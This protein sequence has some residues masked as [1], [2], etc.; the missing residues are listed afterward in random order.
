MKCVIQ[1]ENARL[2]RNGQAIL[3]N[4][5]ISIM[6]GQTV[7]VTGHNGSGKSTLVKLL[8]G[9]HE[10]SDGKVIRNF[11]FYG[12]VPEHF[13][14]GIRLTVARYLEFLVQMSNT[15]QEKVSQYIEQFN[16]TP[17]LHTSLKN[18]SKGTKQKVGFIQAIMKEADV[19]FFD[20]PFTGMDEAAQQH[21]I[22]LLLSLRGEK[23]MVF[24]LHEEALVQQLATHR[25]TLP[26]GKMEKL[27]K[28]EN[29]K[30]RS[31]TVRSE[32]PVEGALQLEEN[33]YRLFVPEDDSD[34]R[35]M[36]LLTAGCRVLEVGE[37]R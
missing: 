17:Y 35:L 5:N 36:Q 6:E 12:Y 10:P 37:K 19:L 3:S 18:C 30:M 31:I 24:V 7:A 28:K 23:T 2:D 21:A 4:L 20:E 34:E 1:T 14:E 25:I 15:D 16:L 32:Q 33:I 9:I 11:Q 22:N 27:T 26:S 13:P 29:Q 8:S